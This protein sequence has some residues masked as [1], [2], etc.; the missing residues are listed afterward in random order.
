MT[1]RE[2]MPF[3][4]V[5]VGGGPAGLATAIHLAQLLEKAQSSAQ[6]VVLEKG[7]E[8]GSHAISGAVMDP[9]GLD[10]LLPGWR[11]MEPKPP[12]ECEVH[13]DYALWL[14]QS[15]G[16]RFPITPPTL[17]NH[18]NYVVSLNKLVRWLGQVAE[19]KGVQV[20][21]GFPGYRLVRA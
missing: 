12:I 15:G 19:Q 21:P 13:D 7:L 1:D 8:V 11:T 10:A 14:T 9:S 6:I 3:D 20:F 5:I 16:W 17:R 2:T 4:V 18:G